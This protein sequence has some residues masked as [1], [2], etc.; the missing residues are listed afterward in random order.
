MSQCHWLQEDDSSSDDSDDTDHEDD[1]EFM[2]SE[3]LANLETLELF[4]CT[5]RAM[6][7]GIESLQ[8]LMVLDL[9]SSSLWQVPAEIGALTLLQELYLDSCGMLDVL[10]EEIGLLAS[11]RILN[12]NMSG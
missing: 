6:P 3:A 10:P 4:R 9:G 8:R 7:R 1:G 2:F 11:L 12:L 5:I